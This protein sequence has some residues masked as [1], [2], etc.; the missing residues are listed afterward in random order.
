[1]RTCKFKFVTILLFFFSLSSLLGQA[2]V[3]TDTISIPTWEVGAPETNAAF[4]NT[5]AIHEFNRKIYPYP[6]K[7]ILAQN[8]EPKD[9]VAC[10]LENE[11]I[12]VLITPEIGGKLYGAKDKTNDFN[13]FYWHPTVKPALVGLTGA[14]T[15]AGIEWNFP[16]A[17]RHTSFSPVSYR[18]V[19]NKD[20]SKTVWVGETEW[21]YGLRWIV[22]LTIYPNKSVI[23]AKIR[24]LN[25]TELNHSFYMWVTTGQNTNENVQLIYPTRIMTNHGKERYNYWPISDGID[26]SWWKNTPN[27][28]SYFAVEKGGF[29]GSY[30][31]GKD[32]GTVIAGNENI[33][34]GKKFWTW[35]TSP[36]GR[37]W[38][39]IL[40]DD[41]EPYVEPQAGIYSDNQPDF[42][43]MNPQDVKSLSLYFFPVKDVGNFKYANENGAL[44]FDFENKKAKL[45]VYSTAEL[46]GATIK[47]SKNGE[48]IFSEK[49]N[50]SPAKT[51]IKEVNLNNSNESITSY[52]LSLLDENEN[53]LLEYTP[54]EL[55]KIDLP[56]VEPAPKSTSEIESNDDL[57]LTGE[58]FYKFRESEKAI[59]YF[60]ELLKRDPLNTRANIKVAE[61]EIKKAEYDSA[62]KHLDNA[63]KRDNDNGNIFYL[64]GIAN[65]EL[66][67]FETAYKLFYRAVHFQEFISAAYFKIANLDLRNKNYKKAI[68]HIQKSIEYNTL[69]PQLFA[70]K[71]NALRLN[72]D[73]QEAEKT[74]KH[75]LDLDPLNTWALNELRVIQNNLGND[76]SESEELLTQVLIDD[77]QY[78]LNLANEYLNAG[79]YGCADKVLELA[80]NENINNLAMIYYYKGF[81]Q[82]E[83][84][85]DKSAEEMFE[86]ASNISNE[87][88]FPFRRNSISVLNKALEYNQNDANAYYYLGMIY[89][90]FGNGKEA[91]VNWENSLDKN[92]KNAKAWRNI[93]LLYAGA[94][95][96]EKDI[97]KAKEYYE[98]AFKFAPEDATI[99]N[100]LDEVYA[101]NK[102]STDV[103]YSLLK[104][105]VEVVEKR[106]DILSSYLNLLVE[107]KEY[108]KALSYYQ[109]RI[110]N[111]WEGG[112]HIHSAYVNT[113]LQMAEDAENTE[114]ALKYYKMAALY[115][116]N[117]RVLPREPDWNG[118]ILYPTAEAYAELGKVEQ[119]DSLF[120]IV[121]ETTTTEPTLVTFYQALALKELGKT[122]KSEKLLSEF[123]KQGEKLV[124]EKPNVYLTAL[125]YYYQSKYYEVKNNKQMAEKM[126]NEALSIND[127]IVSRAINTAKMKFARADLTY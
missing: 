91:I 63:F 73:Y 61:L 58:H 42:H 46:S 125:G 120:K 121:A 81:C 94:P 123:L 40:A 27:A 108:Q 78:Y 8:K 16:S 2:K 19:E 103:R 4:P 111:N 69:N 62:I 104:E 68:E 72:K 124:E 5:I 54:Q 100:E 106:D 41:A 112:Y 119:A 116:E 39:M 127:K 71:A 38:D 75:A 107:K 109:N 11:F 118:F 77:Y 29:F 35:G 49:V 105:N 113:L 13:F 53:I 83:L 98:N 28:T 96:V 64:K 1:M 33:M 43:W 14:W 126:L 50:V 3:W 88:V 65:Q 74:A 114:D 80:V 26:L 60:D 66:G 6:Y 57:Y 15:S 101:M 52:T 89:A 122:E 84:N 56:E 59:E 55:E 97:V 92:S 51:F 20:G 67:N 31:H 10:W 93:G 34:V 25:P 95:G 99:L 44:N 36:S 85:N 45:S 90:G 86:L 115:P 9:Y 21:V 22:G 117:L 110:F 70:L 32:V 102:V 30:D 48:E 82:A 18:A 79:L 37:V 87:N 17:H 7:D 76:N 23:E 24:L 47:L 12:K